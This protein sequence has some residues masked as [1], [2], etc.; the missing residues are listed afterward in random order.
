[1]CWLFRIHRISNVKDFW[2]S[3][4]SLSINDKSSSERCRNS[5]FPV[6]LVDFYR[7]QLPALDRSNWP[8]ESSRIGP[9]CS[10][11]HLPIAKTSCQQ[12]T[13]CHSRPNLHRSNDEFRFDILDG[14]VHLD[15]QVDEKLIQKPRSK[16][17]FLLS[18]DFLFQLFQDQCGI[19]FIG[20][21]YQ[22]ME[23]THLYI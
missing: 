22:H 3:T 2:H 11:L 14:P 8:W 9:C 21:I 4:P 23:M 12:L 6:I 19:F 1:M 17:L 10:V 20:V 15:K 5:S 18:V 16:L 7:F 13:I